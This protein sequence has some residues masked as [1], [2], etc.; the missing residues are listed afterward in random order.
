MSFLAATMLWAGVAVDVWAAD[1]LEPITPDTIA[2]SP[3]VHEHRI[4][5]SR[6]EYEA[7]QIAIRTDEPLHAVSVHAAPLARGLP[8]PDVFRVGHVAVDG[9]LVADPLYPIM[10]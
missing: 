2:P 1:A 4:Y 7:F 10:A 3:D 6:G 8:A 5:L 9:A